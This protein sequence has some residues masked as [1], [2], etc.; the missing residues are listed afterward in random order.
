[1]RAFRY[2]DPTPAPRVC[3]LDEDVNRILLCDGCD[4]EYHC[5]CVEPPLLEVSGW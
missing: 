2:A 3:W 4:G 5:Y 1:M